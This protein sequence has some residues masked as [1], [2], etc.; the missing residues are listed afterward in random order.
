MRLLAELHRWGVPPWFNYGLVELA[1]NVILFFPLGALV[2]RIMGVRL[3]WSAAI[4]GF[5]ISVAI[6]LAQLAFLP[7]RFPSVVDVA[8]NTCGAA[9]GALTALLFMARRTAGR[10]GHPTRTL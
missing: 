7:A 1:S 6:E 8:A 9:L 10:T 3:W 5:L 2:A 4:A